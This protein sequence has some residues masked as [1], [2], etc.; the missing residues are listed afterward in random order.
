MRRTG[1]SSL[2][3][4]LS[5]GTNLFYPMRGPGQYSKLCYAD[6]RQ[7]PVS[8]FR[9]NTSDFH[10]EA[11]LAGHRVTGATVLIA[12]DSAPKLVVERPC[13]VWNSG[14]ARVQTRACSPLAQARRRRRDALH[15]CRRG[16]R[17]VTVVTR[18]T[19]CLLIDHTRQVCPKEC[20]NHKVPLAGILVKRTAVAAW[21]L[22]SDLTRRYRSVPASCCLL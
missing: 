13:F 10:R 7:L 22:C 9:S 6:T 16:S 20:F 19:A 12:M 14:S 18:R 1:Q 4:R 2:T 8:V 15:L 17:E 11:G 21:A 3:R 5:N